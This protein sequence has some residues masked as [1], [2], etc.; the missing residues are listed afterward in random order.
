MTF[1]ITG[2]GSNRR[3]EISHYL[4]EFNPDRKSSRQ[5]LIDRY[6]RLTGVPGRVAL[7]FVGQAFVGR[8]IKVTLGEEIAVKPL[9]GYVARQT[10]LQQ[11]HFVAGMLA[12]LRLLSVRQQLG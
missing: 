1:G 3:R 2:D 6:F 7:E 5:N 9:L 11:L 4:G 8:R 10:R 12:S